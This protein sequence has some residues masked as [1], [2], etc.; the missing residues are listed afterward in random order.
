MPKSPQI[1]AVPKR[2]YGWLP[3]VPD[4]RD[5]LYS[6]PYVNLQALPPKAD[7]RQSCPPISNQ[8]SLGNCTSNVLAA[9]IQF[10]RLR[11][12]LEP[13]LP[14]RLFEGGSHLRTGIK[15]AVK[16]VLSYQRLVQDLN[17]MRG[18]LASGYP[19]V[20]GF[21]VYSSFE[22]PQVARKG[23]VPMPASGERQLGGHAVMAV[24]YDDYKQGFI[25]RNSWGK[26]W[27]MDGYFMMPYTYLCQSSLASD[28]WTIRLR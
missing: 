4:Q 25:V 20:F 1:P 24:G 27:G 23:I 28:F 21:A 2:N 7:L 13:F 22:C 10:D 5:F 6:A 17:Q 18:C 19:F 9:A 26:E 15:R 16:Q 12:K 3:D 11:Q 14:S 8:G